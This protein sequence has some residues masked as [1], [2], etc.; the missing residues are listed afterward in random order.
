MSI[1]NI[2][3]LKAYKLLEI[4]NNNMIIDVRTAEEWQQVG[5]PKLD[6]DKIIFISW[7]LLPNMSLNN[8][9]KNQLMSK[10]SNIVNSGEF[11]ARSDGAMPISNRRATSDDVP[12]FSSIDYNYKLLFLC[13]SGGR[14]HEAAQFAS[15]L[16]YKE[17]YNIIDGFEGGTNGAGWKQNNLPW[18]IL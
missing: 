4:D 6:K 10:I 13:R 18:Q 3:S 11:G 14:S 16:G 8:E 7:R 9:F 15:T 1:K 5:I 12:N 2:S 17:C